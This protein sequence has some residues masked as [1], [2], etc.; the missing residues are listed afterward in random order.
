MDVTRKVRKEYLESYY[1]AEGAVKPSST[2]DNVELVP[3]LFRMSGFLPAQI[4]ITFGMI[5]SAPTIK[6]TIFF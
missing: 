5:L 1:I 3:R 6:N 2:Q 4:P